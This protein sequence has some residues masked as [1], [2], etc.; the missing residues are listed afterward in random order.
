MFPIDFYVY[1]VKNGRKKSQLTLG[2]ALIQTKLASEGDVEVV[3]IELITLIVGSLAMALAPAG[4]KG[5]G[6]GKRT[7]SLSVNAVLFFLKKTALK[8]M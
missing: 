5:D 3:A 1:L 4:T 7:L 2:Q 6:E 8:G